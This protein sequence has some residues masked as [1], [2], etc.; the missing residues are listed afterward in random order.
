MTDVPRVFREC[1]LIWSLRRPAI[2]SRRCPEDVSIQNFL[3]IFFPVK[4]SIRCVKQGLLHLKNTFP[5]NHQFLG[6]SPESPLKVPWKSWTLGTLGDFQ[7]TSPGRHGWEL[8]SQ[9]LIAV[10]LCDVQNSDSDL[11][12][13]KHMKDRNEKQHSKLI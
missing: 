11:M 7:R 9:L 5:L 4:N 8:S 6:W 2:G 10:S 12:Q 13:Y 3:N 1:P